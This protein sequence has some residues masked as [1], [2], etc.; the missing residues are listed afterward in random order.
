V[1]LPSCTMSAS[2]CP[3]LCQAWGWGSV[4]RGQVHWVGVMSFGRGGVGVILTCVEGSAP[5]RITATG[6]CGP[7]QNKCLIAVVT[8]L[9]L[10]GGPSAQGST[11]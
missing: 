2:N 5:A 3:Q 6:C 4:S 1:A 11:S 10:L 8:G 9:T 7:Q